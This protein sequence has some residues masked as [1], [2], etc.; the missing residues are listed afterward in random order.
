MADEKKNW[1]QATRDYI[2]ELKLEMRRVFLAKP[3]A[4]GRHHG[5]GD[6]RRF[7]LRGLLWV[8]G[9]DTRPRRQGSSFVLHE[10][11]G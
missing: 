9:L 6:F 1:F 7:R 8:A 2:N 11:G 3:E 5:G 4:G 10:V